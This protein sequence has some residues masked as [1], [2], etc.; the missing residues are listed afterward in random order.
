MVA[1][2]RIHA[3]GAAGDEH[4]GRSSRPEDT[5][6]LLA[7]IAN[8][9]DGARPEFSQWPSGYPHRHRLKDGTIVEIE[10]T[11]RTLDLGG[12]ECRIAYF[13][14]VTE[15]NRAAAELQAASATRRWPRRT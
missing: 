9:P 12:R 6:L 4:P 2:L 1:K 14:D 10:V 5:E 3:R 11:S 15:R 13:E 7:F 8:T